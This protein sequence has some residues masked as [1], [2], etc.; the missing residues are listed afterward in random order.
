[1]SF[2]PNIPIGTDPILQSQAQLKA[3]FQ[4]I[5]QAFSNNH[6]PLTS[7]SDFSGM[8]NVI[9]LRPQTGDPT[10]GVDQTAIYNK[11]VASIPEMF[12]RPNSDQTPIQMT[13]PS[14][15]T[16]L[17]TA[18][19]TYFPDQYS[20]AAGPFIIY[21]GLIK[22]VSN[23]D[24]KTLAPGTNL[25]YID[26]IVVSLAFPTQTKCYEAIPTNILG[27]SFNMTWSPTIL[28]KLDIYYFAIGQ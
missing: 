1:M 6:I 5:G 2:N 4:A 9:T 13:Y 28:D 27:T 21:G 14:I 22:G 3:N 10:T 16:G 24:G 8:H 15:R 23:G 11:I 17:Q 26:L 12:F 19:D 18:P 7:D 20:F 25:I